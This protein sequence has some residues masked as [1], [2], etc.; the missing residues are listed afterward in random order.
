[1]RVILYPHGGSGNHGCEAIVRSTLKIL[2]ADA[3]LYSSKIQEDIKFGLTDICQVFPER[4]NLSRLSLSYLNAI[5]RYHM[6]KDR[7]AFD[8]AVYNPLINGS[9]NVDFA[10]SIGGD[11]YCYGAPKYI[12]LINKEL[13]K[14]GVKT[15]LWGASIEPKS[16]HGEMLED[17][18]G[19]THIFARESITYNAL[20]KNG[21]F[22]V[23][24]HPDPAFL[25]DCVDLRLPDGFIDG[26][27]VGI[28]LSPMIIGNENLRGITLCNYVT[29]IDYIIAHTDMQV[30]LIPHVVW[31]HNDD[32]LPLAKLFEPFKNSGRVMMIEDHDASVLKGFIG[33]CRFMIAARTHASIAAY[34]QH[35]PTLVVGYSVKARGIAK[36]IYGTS[37]NY[38]IPVQS[39]NRPD[40]LTN[41]FKWLLIHET[42]ILDHY[43]S[44]M[45]SYIARAM[46]AG[47]VLKRL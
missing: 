4:T 36:D 6:L 42:Q 8:K 43:A 46:D 24:L 19:Y 16:I 7:E 25:L 3:I 37:D 21:I 33:R 29:L 27:T 15:V 1:M 5:I 45:P 12:Y 28:N 22:K 11:N 31:L 41:A 44:F 40:D 10:L 32:R 13:R 35:V 34:S 47:E 18:K 23:S 2:N 14:K 30:A 26:N 9:K 20:K 38:V 39:L 17:L